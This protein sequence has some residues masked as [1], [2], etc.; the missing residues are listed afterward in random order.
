MNY[1]RIYDQII[2]RAKNRD[3]I[4]YREKHHIIPRCLGGSNSK[5]NLVE[6]TAREHF[7]C[8]WLLHEMYPD[9]YK[10]AYAFN[11]MCHIKSSS[12][13]D[14]VPSS[15]VVEYSRKQSTKL[16]TGENNPF[17]NK[18]HSEEVI[19]KIKAKLSN[20]RHSE[21]SKLKMGRSR[22]GKENPQYGK[23]STKRKKV[24]D[25]QNSIIFD[26]IKQ[27][28]E[29]F[30]ISSSAIIYRIRKGALRYYKI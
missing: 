18:K 13:K 22:Y 23:P 15:R 7:L 3:L 25:P 16:S 2:D 14:Y 20:F 12:A 8:H 29:H 9:N 27:A 1:K 26:S 19:S 5:E 30:G 21:E 10:L 6:L 11:K 24:I 17:F 4:G 28:G